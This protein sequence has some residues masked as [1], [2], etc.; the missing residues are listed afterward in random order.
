MPSSLRSRLVLLLILAN[1]PAAALAI[2]ATMKGRDAEIDQRQLGLVQRAEVIATRAGLTL[3]IAEG[4]ADTLAANDQVASAGPDCAEHL[5]AALV[6]RPEYNGIIVSDSDGNILC[7][8][9]DTDVSVGGLSALRRAIEN[10]QDVGDIVFLPERIPPKDDVVLMSRAFS[11]PD[12]RRRAIGLLLRRDVFDAIFLPTEPAPPEKSA[13][14]LIR[15]NGNIVSEFIPASGGKTWQPSVP[16]PVSSPGEAGIGIT[17]PTAYGTQYHYAIAPVRGTLSSVVLAT[18]LAVVNA[19]DWMRFATALAA[20]LLMLVLGIAAVFAGLDRL[21]L[22]WIGRFG[23][24]TTA[25]ARGDY[26]PRIGE[27]ERAPLELS[28]LGAGINDMAGRVQERST[29]LEEALSGKNA[30]LRELHHRVKNN[31]QMIA[32]LLALQRR[33]LPT[34]LRTLLRVPEDRVLAMAAAYKASY[35]TGEIGHVS[36]LDLLRDV[37]VQLRQSFGLEAPLIQTGAEDEPAWLDLDQAVPLGLLVS[38]ILTATLD[39]ADGA[40]HP[41]EVHVLRPDPNTIHVAIASRRVADAIPSTGLAARLV[42][43]YRAQLNAKIVV[44]DEDRIVIAMPSERDTQSHPGRVD[45]G[46]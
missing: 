26:A 3:G 32:S 13:L 39:R 19:T 7:S 29:A 42:A 10:T 2:G 40:V 33:E 37:A 4:V 34:R 31:F 27:L 21:V 11:L 30:L 43:A 36:A 23:Q 20:P 46:S 22:R 9:G 15:G 44:A 41:I 16:L 12:G 25:Y 35:A 5:K 8:F 18:P 38:E 14:A 1:L 28:E 6:F 45:L 24:V 17:R